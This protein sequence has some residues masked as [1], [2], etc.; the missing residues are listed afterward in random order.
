MKNRERESVCVLKRGKSVCVCVGWDG[1]ERERESESE[2]VKNIRFL[3]G[4]A[5]CLLWSTRASWHAYLY[6]KDRVGQIGFLPFFYCYYVLLPP[7]NK[8]LQ[9]VSDL[10]LKDSVVA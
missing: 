3:V 6:T 4:L 2:R 9:S 5:S 1:R 10:Y 7:F 8:V